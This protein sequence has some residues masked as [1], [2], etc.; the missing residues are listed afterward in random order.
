[1]ERLKGFWSRPFILL[2][3]ALFTC[4]QQ[5]RLT[6][7]EMEFDQHSTLQV[8]DCDSDSTDSYCYLSPSHGSQATWRRSLQVGVMVNAWR[9]Q[10]V[11][12]SLSWS[13]VPLIL[14]G[15]FSPL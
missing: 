5:G 13:F 3:K 10:P 14:L 15:S 9:T 8:S 4:T 7:L 1:M 6:E 2:Q 12:H 11:R